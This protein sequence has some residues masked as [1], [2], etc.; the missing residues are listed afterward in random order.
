LLNEK[1][2]LLMAAIGLFPSVT[3]VSSVNCIYLKTVSP[4]FRPPK[5]LLHFM[6]IGGPK[7]ERLLFSHY[8]KSI[9]SNNFVQM[10]TMYYAFSVIVMATNYRYICQYQGERY[11]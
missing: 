9:N 4:E 7:C 8:V 5:S 2:F 6:N 11:G 1:R 3:A 10:S